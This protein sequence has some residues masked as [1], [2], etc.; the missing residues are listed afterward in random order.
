MKRLRETMAFSLVEVTLAI[1]VAA[2][3]LLAVVALL[4]VGTKVSYSSTQETGATNILGAV[5]ADMRATPASA[6]ASSQYGISF[7]SGDETTLYF[8]QFG[9]YSTM[10]DSKSVYRLVVTSNGGSGAT[11][12]NL[13]VTWPAAA[14]P[15]NAA[16]SSEIFAAI[17]RN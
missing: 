2:F 12:V 9:N 14:L 17:S 1:G 10:L 8:D 6:T 15:A 11:F 4:P 7:A 3:C 16:G 13:K 5:V